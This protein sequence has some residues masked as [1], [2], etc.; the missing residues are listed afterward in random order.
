MASIDAEIPFAEEFESGMMHVDAHVLHVTAAF[1]PEVGGGGGNGRNGRLRDGA[2]GEGGRQHGVGASEGDVV[3]KAPIQP[4][5]VQQVGE[6]PARRGGRPLGETLVHS[7]SGARARV[8]AS[9][10]TLPSPI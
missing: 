3:G 9:A 4:D 8:S 2:D 7:F 6:H 10:R 5:V 1:A